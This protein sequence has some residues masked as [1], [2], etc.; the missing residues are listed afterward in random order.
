MSHIQIVAI[1]RQARQLRAEEMRR[2][3]RLSAERTNQY[4]HLLG[5]ALVSLGNLLSAMLRPLFS[6]NPREASLR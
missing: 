5:R 3:G 6:W 1:E 4:F 2:L